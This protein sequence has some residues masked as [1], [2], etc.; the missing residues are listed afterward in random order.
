M[1]EPIKSA[2]SQ[3]MGRYYQSLSPTTKAMSEFASRGLGKSIMVAPTRMIDVAEDMLAAWQRNDT[4]SAPTQPPKLPVIIIAFAR[5]MI[6]TGRD[7]NRQIADAEHISLEGDD[8]QRVF[9][10]RTVASDVRVQV[11]I[12]AHEEPT[13]RAL[14]AQFALFIDAT[15]NQHLYAKFD[16]PLGISEDWPIM[17]EST[18]TPFIAVR[19]EAK[20]LCIIAADL[21]LKVTVPIYS[22]PNDENPNNAQN[23]VPGTFDPSG[24]LGVNEVVINPKESV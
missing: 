11:A 15:G 22:A 24:Y 4:D 21:T 13:A 12:F 8:K 3:F 7:F 6:P 18:E 2:F 10:I 23:G 19:T 5:D 1:F 9:K 17:I 16:N 20:N 14:A